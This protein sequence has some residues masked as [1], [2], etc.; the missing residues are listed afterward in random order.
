M[1]TT[2]KLLSQSKKCTSCT[3]MDTI[4][5]VH[6]FGWRTHGSSLVWME[7]TWQFTCLDGEHMAAHLFG[8]RTH[9]SS[10]VWM[11]NTRQ[12]TCLNGLHMGNS[13]VY[14]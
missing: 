6:L 1:H 8:W 13:L 2:D 12:L 11:E 9:G 7:N 14:V 10:L 5:S 3:W 4:V